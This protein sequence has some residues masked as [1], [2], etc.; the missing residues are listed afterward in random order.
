[1]S[2]ISYRNF[3]L[4]LKITRFVDID[5]VRAVCNLTHKVT[6]VSVFHPL[7]P[8]LLKFRTEDV[9]KNIHE[10][11]LEYSFYYSLALIK[12]SG[13]YVS[14]EMNNVLTMVPTIYYLT[15]LIASGGPTKQLR[16]Q[17]VSVPFVLIGPSTHME[18]REFR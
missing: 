18:K 15:C 5:L 1:M 8:G 12:F 10:L 4:R 16:T 9:D 3:P 13:S 2:E 17:T 6:L 7:L 11:Q 14:F